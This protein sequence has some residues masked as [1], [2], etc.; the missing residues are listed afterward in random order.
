MSYQY[1]INSF[2]IKMY[3]SIFVVEKHYYSNNFEEREPSDN[4]IEKFLSYD[5]EITFKNIF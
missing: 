3:L 4:F 5:N 1:F 2:K